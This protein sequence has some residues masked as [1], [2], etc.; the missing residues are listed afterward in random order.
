MCA[1]PDPAATE[2]AGNLFRGVELSGQG[3]GDLGAR[4]ARAARR[5]IEAGERALLIGTDCLELGPERLRAAAAALQTYSAVIYPTADGGYALLGL[6]RFD[7]SLFDGI[8]WS[9]PS[10]AAATLARLEALAWTIHVGETL[11]D[12]D[13]P[14]DLD[15]ASESADVPSGPK[16]L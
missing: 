6:G 5:T 14:A 9:T 15:W 11:R 16:S 12:V 10:V 2:W 8:A 1:D 7:P 3:E 13:E 4:L